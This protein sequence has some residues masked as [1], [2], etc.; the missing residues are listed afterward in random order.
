MIGLTPKQLAVLKFIQAHIAEHGYSP[1]YREIM[2]A[3]GIASTSNVHRYI[4][5]LIYR[6]HLSS[7]A[8]RARSLAPVADQRL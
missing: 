1:S 6:G 4:Q 8:G 5:A 7:A 2:A 3:C